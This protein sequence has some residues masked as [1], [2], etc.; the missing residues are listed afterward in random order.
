[1]MKNKDKQIMTPKELKD[2]GIKVP[3]KLKNIKC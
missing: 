1:M 3:G 2:L